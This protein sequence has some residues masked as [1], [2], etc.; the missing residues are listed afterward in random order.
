MCGLRWTWA[1]VERRRVGVV[2]QEDCQ[3]NGLPTNSLEDVIR[4]TLSCYLLFY[5]L[6]SSGHFDEVIHRVLCVFGKRK[7]CMSSVSH[8]LLIFKFQTDGSNVTV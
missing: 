6:L 4:E 7:Q 3:G 1:G 8:L 2:T 5:R